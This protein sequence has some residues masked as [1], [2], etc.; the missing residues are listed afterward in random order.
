MQAEQDLELSLSFDTDGWLAATL[1]APSR[2]VDSQAESPDAIDCEFLLYSHPFKKGGGV[3]PPRKPSSPETAHGKSTS[4]RY[5]DIWEDYRSGENLPSNRSP[6]TLP[7]FQPIRMQ[8][9]CHRYQ[10][11]ATRIHCSAATASAPPT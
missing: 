11:A 7:R 5:K 10:P 2:S 9:G 6:T 8:L 1:P 4:F 3:C